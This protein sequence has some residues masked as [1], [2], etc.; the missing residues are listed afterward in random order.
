MK[1]SAVAGY[2]CSVTQS[3]SGRLPLWDKSTWADIRRI[4]DNRN[5]STNHL[6]NYGIFGRTE[7]SRSTTASTR[8]PHLAAQRSSNLLEP[9]L[10]GFQSISH[11]LDG[12]IA[13]PAEL[14]SNSLSK[15][16]QP[17]I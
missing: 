13:E 15:N 12:L 1:C 6:P 5:A 17:D 9:L 4:V 2:E 11:P 7:A 10:S 3:Q 16:W 8:T 14:A